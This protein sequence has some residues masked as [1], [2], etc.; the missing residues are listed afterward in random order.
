V[1]T[2]PQT[3]NDY[4]DPANAPIQHLTFN[5]LASSL[6]ITYNDFSLQICKLPF[7]S[8]ITQP[9]QQKAPFIPRPETTPHSTIK[10]P[11]RPIFSHLYNNELLSYGNKIYNIQKSNGKEAIPSICNFGE[12]ANHAAWFY[13]D[14]FCVISKDNE[15]KVCKLKLSR[16]GGGSTSQ[17]HLQAQSKV[18]QKYSHEGAN[19]ILALACINTSL[20]HLIASSA[21][22]KSLTL[23]DVA[24]GKSYWSVKAGCGS[25][26][27]H[28]IALPNVSCNVGL[29]AECYCLLACSSTDSGGLVKLWDVRS[30]TPA[31]Q[32]R[33]HVN[34]REVCNVS[35]S[36]CMRYIS[37]GSEDQN[38]AVV[39]D[40]RG[41]GG[42]GESNTIV[43]R[44]R[45]NFKD[46]SIVDVQYNPIYP[47]MC[48]GSTCGVV[49]FYSE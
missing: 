31:A 42:E 16:V 24:T 6:A 39:Y 12:N 33:G 10:H 23:S 32:L 9:S 37:C 19:T 7:K 34:R 47:Q 18:V 41:G 14:K 17:G 4:T 26:A 21:S 20:S 5:P 35:F 45:K 2:N 44:C 48:T 46:G 38:G 11:P 36:P 30:G 8:F 29:P 27:A 40:L 1:L 28:C 15:I 13:N 25:R 3:Q 22:D 43:G 49:K